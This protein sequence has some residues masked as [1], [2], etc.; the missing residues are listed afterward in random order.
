MNREDLKQTVFDLMNGSINLE[1][2]PTEESQHVENEFEQGKV[3]ATAYQQIYEANQ[4][5]CNRLGTDEDKDVECIISNFFD[6][7][8][9]LSMKMYDYGTYYARQ[10]IT[11]TK[12]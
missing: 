4:R 1:E 5:L 11:D 12:K 9:H 3:C 2:F 8:H 7:I 10:E 6:I